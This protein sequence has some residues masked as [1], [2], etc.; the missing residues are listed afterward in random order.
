MPDLGNG[1]VREAQR[2]R[3]RRLFLRGKSL[4]RWWLL[5]TVLGSGVGV[6]ALMVVP[7]A[8]F[9]FVADPRLW[10]L[11][12]FGIVLFPKEIAQWLVLRR[13]A[14]KTGYWL[15]GPLIG[16]LAGWGLM[17]AKPGESG[18][19]LESVAGTLVMAYLVMILVQWGVL[20][21]L[22]RQTGGWFFANAATYLV[23]GKGFQWLEIPTNLFTGLLAMALWGFFTSFAIMN[24]LGDH[25]RRAGERRGGEL[26]GGDQQIGDQRAVHRNRLF[27]RLFGHRLPFPDLSLS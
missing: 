20:Y 2:E 8:D 9:I 1:V 14:R 22:F 17:W 16:A 6:A 5:A 10:T 7:F 4:R 3:A 25:R 11:A 21:L 27:P 26:G 18:A 15:L 13:Y 24:A 23:A 19:P 12:M